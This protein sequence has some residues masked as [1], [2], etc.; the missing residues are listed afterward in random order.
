MQIQDRYNILEKFILL[1]SIKK[2]NI[3]DRVSID[4]RK[5]VSGKAFI[6]L[7]KNKENNLKNILNA[8]EYGAKSIVTCFN[9]SRSKFKSSIP[10]Y[11]DNKLNDIFYLIYSKSLEKLRYKN[12]IIGI[13]GT[14]GKTSTSLLLSKA[15]VN[16]NKKVGVIT[17]E[18]IGI[19]PKLKSNQYTTPPIDIV[20]ESVF[21]FIAKKVDFIIIEC[22]SQGLDQ[23]RMQGINFDYSMIT[24][25]SSDHLDYH[26]SFS[27]YIKSKMRLIDLSKH[28]II[29][30]D[31]IKNANQIRKKYYKKI[32][33]LSNNSR[34]TGNHIYSDNYVMYNKEK[35]VLS[36]D[37]LKVANKYSIYLII[38]LLKKLNY[39]KKS[40]LNALRGLQ[41]IKGRRYIIKTKSRGI[42]IVDY[43]HTESSYKDIYNMINIK[44][45][46]IT[47]LFGCGGDRDRSKRPRIAKIVNNYS[48]SIIFT[49]DNSR[50]EKFDSI[51]QD[52]L[53]G[54]SSKSKFCILKSRKN[55]I[56]K[57]YNRSKDNH[58]NFI[59]GKGN[60]D[61]I[62]V[63]GQSKAHNDIKFI[64]NLIKNDNR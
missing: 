12:V 46:Y 19:Y 2:N 51:K 28:C 40:I 5:N 8:I 22:S 45:Y 34:L 1:N 35:L 59:L 9:F 61:Y 29:N 15:L 63:S 50:N 44:D 7:S 54:V 57:I 6:S 47:T 30:Y 48:N 41:A 13:T 21:S 24:N 55:A 25:I 17:S 39:S 60:E 16:L 31:G 14:D 26:S 53:N 49:E 3:T 58:V 4:S 36:K 56:K 62:L 38:L 42:F 18:G 33:I 20:Y 10:V 23:N 43:A 27:N 37:V 11:V 52:V 64:K 32:S